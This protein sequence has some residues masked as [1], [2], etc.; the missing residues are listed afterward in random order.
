MALLELLAVRPLFVILTV[1]LGL[2]IGSFLNVVIYRLAAH[3]AAGM[4]GAMRGTARPAN[5]GR[6]A[7]LSL[8][9]P[10]S[11]CPHR[12][13]LIGA[14]ENIPLL[15][16]I[17]QRGRCAHCGVAIAPS[18]RWWKRRWIT[19]RYRGLETRLRLAGDGGVAVHLD[20]VS[21]QRH[22]P[23]SPPLPDDLTLPL[24]WLGLLAALFGLGTDLRNCRDRRHGWL[25]VALA[26]HPG[27]PAADRQRKAGPW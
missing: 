26:G 1:L 20:P 10:R 24:L 9:G 27:L 22:R 19:G 17:R 2:M 5:P 11:Q 13:H 14:T 15:S 18:I 8:W 3:D 23:P 4:A 12:H 16:Y 7:R 25:S 21:G 6:H